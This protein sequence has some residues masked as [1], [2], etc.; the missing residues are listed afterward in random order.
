MAYEWWVFAHLVG[1]VGFMTAHGVSV[2][3]A[4][5]LRGERDPGRIT[6]LLDLSARTV[7]AF[8][9]SFAVLLGCGVIAAFVGDWWGFGWI[10]AAILTLIVVTLAMLFM[11]RPYYQRVRFITRA[12]AEG[13][14]AVTSEQLDEVLLSRRPMTVTWIGVAGLVF[15]LYLM[16]LKPTFG[17]APGAEPPPPAAAGRPVVELAADQSR[18]LATAL[19]V[20]AGN[21]F[22]IRF[23]NREA[24]P[25][26]VS[27][28]QGS[29]SVFTGATFAGPT[30]KNYAVPALAAGTYLFRCDLHPTTM[31]GTLTAG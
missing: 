10:W 18:F 2:A 9:W 22:T 15:I 31:T 28:R 25:H 16:I 27:I 11:A 26:N 1:V 4:L 8:Y 5:R 13:S 20:P 19:S 17:M 23:E 7:P 3:V 24:V 30:S 21:P 14:K 12:M 6:G 29:R